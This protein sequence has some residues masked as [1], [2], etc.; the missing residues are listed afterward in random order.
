MTS[1]VGLDVSATPANT[2]TGRVHEGSGRERL[3][4]NI[5][6]AR[7]LFSFLLFLFH[8]ANAGLPAPPIPFVN[9]YQLVGTSL[10][11]GVDLF[12]VISG[13]VILGAFRRARSLRAFLIDRATRI[14]PVL[15]VTVSLILAMFLLGSNRF[16]AFSLVEIAGIYGANLLAMPPIAWVPLIHPAAWSLSYEFAFYIL[17]ALFGVSTRH[18][19]VRLSFLVV[20]LLSIA[21]FWLHVRA[22]FFLAGVIIGAGWMNRPALLPI[23]RYPFAWM[24]VFFAAWQTL[25]V[26]VGGSIF[27]AVFARLASDPLLLTL[28][29]LSFASALL[30]MSGIEQGL[31]W[32]SHVL[33]R[34]VMQWMGTV[35]YSLYLW[36]TPIMALVKRGLDATDLWTMAG[37]LSQPLFF[38]IALPP[39]LFVSH[40]S[41]R[42]LEIS[43]TNWLRQWRYSARG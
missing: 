42:Y 36:Q 2:A 1:E 34:P 8:V 5:H 43:A 40:L 12:F 17:V 35:S 39:T 4:R 6:G 23:L 13:I 28:A 21:T 9:A 32:T 20:A 41:Q 16:S 30:A 22:S 19:G 11:F 14:F 7:G 27:A 18:V 33:R 29:A 3:N 15:W 26:L 37:S 25:A 24:I 10:A 38:L 31:G